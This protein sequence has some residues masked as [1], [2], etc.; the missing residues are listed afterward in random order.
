MESALQN[1]ENTKLRTFH[2]EALA[3]LSEAILANGDTGRAAHLAERALEV[4][5]RHHQRGSEA[6][7]Q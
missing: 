4:A 3:V 7:A 1:D 2:A 5:R 6:R